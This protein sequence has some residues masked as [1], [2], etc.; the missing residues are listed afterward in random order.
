MRSPVSRVAAAV[1]FVLAIT[2]VAL[3]FHGSGATRA[4][5]DFVKPILEAKTAK[6]K[7]TT[8]MKNPPKGQP[9]VTVTGEVMVLDATR[10]RQ[11]MEVE[12]TMPDKPKT[13][14]PNKS[15]SVMIFDWGRGKS[16]TLEPESKKAMVVTLANMTKEQALKQ[17]MFAQ[18]HSILL[19]AQDKPDVKR[20]PLGEKEIDGRRVVGFRVNVNGT[21]LSL[22]GDP[23]TGLPVRAEMTM[24][25]FPNVKTTMTDFEFNVD[26]DESLFSVEPPPG[27][28]VQNQKVDVSPVEEKS[29]IETFRIYSELSRG[30]F[31]ESLDMQ[32][33]MM[34][35]G[36]MIGKKSA[37][38]TI[39]EKLASGKR[40][41]SEEQIHKVEELMDKFLEWQINPEKKP[42]EEEMRKLEEEMRKTAGMEEGLKEGLEE[43]AGGKGKL[44][45]E[46]IRKNA[47]AAAKKNAEVGM[48]EFMKIQVPLQRGLIFVFTLPPE[49]DAHYAGKGVSLGAADKPIFWYRPKDAKT[50]RVIYGD[51]SVR[52]A[53]VAPTVHDAEPVPLKPSPKQ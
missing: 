27:Y 13:E 52:D 46:E 53:D 38:K 9:A 18:F 44:S 37:M 16:L 1:I 11:E 30:D 32:P 29:L 50:Y 6:Y 40:K 28:T 34:K 12:M 20:E 3:L 17:D 5:A 24:A 33:M 47:Q 4:F 41:L 15:K 2:G 42:N 7:T 21:V 23:K 43:L 48:K 14:K 19:D 49:A 36:M 10:S 22:W 25:M 26:L 45:E 31:P 39:R 8:E 51:L 35:V